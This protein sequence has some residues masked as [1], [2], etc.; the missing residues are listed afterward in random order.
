MQA[1]FRADPRGRAQ[2]GTAALARVDRPYAKYDDMAKDLS[3][4][5]ERPRCCVPRCTCTHDHGYGSDKDGSCSEDLYD[6]I[7]TAPPLRREASSPEKGFVFGRAVAS[8]MAT[9]G[10]ASVAGAW[11]GSAASRVKCIRG[12]T[13]MTACCRVEAEHD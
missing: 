7:P 12:T 3:S 13:D 4:D 8:S 2:D 11:S 1:G 9:G 10:D 6:N 5:E